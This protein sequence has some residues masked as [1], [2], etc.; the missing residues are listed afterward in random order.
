MRTLVG[1]PRAI[2]DTSLLALCPTDVSLEV[3]AV[4][5]HPILMTSALGNG[6]ATESPPKAITRSFS[7][8]LDVACGY[9]HNFEQIEADAANER[10]NLIS[11]SI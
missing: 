4:Q 6:S 9:R 7:R 2:T 3:P 8:L 5:N 10:L 1:R 11:G